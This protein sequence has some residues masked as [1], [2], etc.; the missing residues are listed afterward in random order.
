MRHSAPT[1]KLLARLALGLLAALA[2]CL[3]AVPALHAQT[4]AY[5]AAGG[6]SSI[7]LANA[8]ANLVYNISSTTFDVGYL[9]EEAGP[10]WEYGFSFTGKPASDLTTQLFQAGSAPPAIGG[11]VSFGHHHIFSP[12]LANLNPS[13]PWRDDWAIVNVTYT[14]SSFYTVPNATTTAVV[15]QQFNGFTVLPTYN[16][17]LNAP[18]MN[19]LLGV[20]AGV[21]RTSNISS[22]TSVT[23]NTPVVQSGSGAAVVQQQ[24]AYLGAFSTSIGVPLYSDLVLIPKKLPWMAFDAFTRSNL[25]R[26]NRY[27]EGG[28][29]LFLAQPGKPTNVLGGISLGWKN[30]ART[31]ALVGGWCF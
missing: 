11:G 10:S 7:Y 27:G 24:S 26:T 5:Q 20:A 6:T 4:A 30:G 2:L 19:V 12:S 8:K 31:I 16:A 18:G 28:I 13:S 22:L 14:G 17:F 23:V 1:S 9:H 21:N 25:A 15:K 3:A 29:G